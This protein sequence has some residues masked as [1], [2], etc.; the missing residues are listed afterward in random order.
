M[1]RVRTLTPN[2]TVLTLKMWAYTAKIAEI[3][4]FGYKFAQKGYTPLS[5]FYKIWLEEGVPGSQPHAKC[6]HCEFGTGDLRSA[7]PCQIS[8]LSGQRVTPAGR[9]T[10]FWTIE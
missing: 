9:K 6:R 4:N 10:H 3:C 1:S 2:F 5:D 7:P 8:R